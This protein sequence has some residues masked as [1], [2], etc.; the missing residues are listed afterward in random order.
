LREGESVL[1][2]RP[3]EKSAG[4]S[5]SLLVMTRG[6]TLAVSPVEVA[7]AG[8][9]RTLVTVLAVSII[10]AVLV[11]AAGSAG[12][13]VSVPKA[14]SA[15]GIGV[16][17]AN[18]SSGTIL[19]AR[20]RK[21]SGLVYDLY[22]VDADGTRLQLVAR[23]VEAA[24][25]SP[26][27]TS[28]A[29]LRDALEIVKSSG[30][31]SVR[32][33]ATDVNSD[34]SRDSFNWSPNGAQLAYANPR[35][36]IYVVGSDGRG[37]RKLIPRQG[38]EPSWSPDG[39]EIAF[40]H[41]VNRDDQTVSSVFV[42]K[43]DGSNPHLLIAHAFKPIWSP[44]GASILFNRQSSRVWPNPTDLYVANADGS[45]TRKV[46]GAPAHGVITSEWSP[47]GHQ[48]AF[49]AVLAP[50]N[51]ITCETST[52]F[53]V[54][55]DGSGLTLIQRDAEGASWSPDGTTLATI[56]KYDLWTVPLD[57]TA[58]RRVTR[59][60]GVP[61]SQWDPRGRHVVDLGLATLE[62]RR[63][64]SP[65]FPGLTI[66]VPLGWAFSGGGYPSSL[67]PE[68]FDGRGVSLLRPPS[69]VYDPG[70]HR[71]V[72]LH[73]S[74]LEWIVKHPHL[75]TTTI[76]NIRLADFPGQMV[77]GHVRSADAG[78]YDNGFCGETMSASPC[79]P[80]TADQSPEG[81]VTLALAP[82]ATFRFIALRLPHR[83]KLLI[84]LDGNGAFIRTAMNV[85]GTLR[86]K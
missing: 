66:L 51:C 59:S 76:K 30:G 15:A 67:G 75:K 60:G 24:R 10:A 43:A 27:G 18:A 61:A 54:N 70:R 73:T 84:E 1:L 44:T 22:L 46:S 16:R 68:R 65:D 77:D 39:N 63:D 40:T 78:A 8:K 32:V 49:S 62:D 72:R 5:S 81:Y 57:G 85:L 53:V 19:F 45:N 31:V 69:T 35:G 23:Q 2:P 86:L 6:G 29:Y 42:M 80:L 13:G 83:R 71:G 58:A 4:G 34:S 20:V 41:L 25:W 14:R 52:T 36:A 74:F 28:V 7:V 38:N 3:D 9:G 26:D 21:G 11:G 64:I 55:A 33:S 48:I 37:R 47:D 79:V 56:H 12:T 17:A 50:A 82:R